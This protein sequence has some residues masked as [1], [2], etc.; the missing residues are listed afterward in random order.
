MF[1]TVT[2]I[3]H[4]D[5]ITAPMIDIKPPAKAGKAWTVTEAGREWPATA[6]AVA[7]D[8][9]TEKI[10][11]RADF[12]DF[13]LAAKLTRWTIAAHMG[14]LFGLPN[15]LALLGVAAGLAAMVPLGLRDVV[16]TPAHPRGLLGRR[17]PGTARGVPARPLGR[18][19][20]RHHP[21]GRR[22]TLP[23]PAGLEPSGLPP[24]GHRHRIP[25]NDA[26]GHAQL[27]RRPQKQA[28]RPQTT[29]LR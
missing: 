2:R 8:P 23:A 21:D 14:L 3:A 1:D 26:A 18:S 16:E 24:P 11:S 15:Q 19:A 13:S 17:P 25:S 10:T 22:W 28:P 12:N 6:S 9:A 20:R 5:I 7:I 29:P 27:T 4:A